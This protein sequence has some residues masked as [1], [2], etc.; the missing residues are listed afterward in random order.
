MPSSAPSDP[1]EDA[2]TAGARK[3][4]EAFGRFRRDGNYSDRLA[5]DHEAVE[6]IAASWNDDMER[7]GAADDVRKAAG[8]MR[9]IAKAKPISV[10]T[11]EFT[12]P[13]RPGALGSLE[14][15]TTVNETFAFELGIR[16]VGLDVA[17]IAEGRD[18]AAVKSLVALLG[19]SD[20]QEAQLCFWLKIL[21]MSV[22]HSL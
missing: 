12:R 20:C 11:G 15:Y 22:P 1:A 4:L 19:S 13:G 3:I 14:R 17:Q 7:N 9:R 6:A 16:L 10:P 21:R 8:L 18:N 2:G 5:I